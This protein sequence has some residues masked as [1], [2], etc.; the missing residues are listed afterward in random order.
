M[1]F[2]LLTSQAATVN[3]NDFTPL[4]TIDRKFSHEGMK[5]EV[6][7]DEKGKKLGKVLSVMHNM[8]IALV[9]LNRLDTNGPNH[10]YTLGGH[11]AMFW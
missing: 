4:N 5:G 10:E 11:R 3:V 1:P 6:I 9:D 2:A 7:V 8:G